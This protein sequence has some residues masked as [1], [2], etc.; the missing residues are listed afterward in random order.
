MQYLYY[1]LEAVILLNCSERH[2]YSPSCGQS[3]RPSKYFWLKMGFYFIPDARP[4]S[5]K[6]GQACRP[7]VLS[8]RGGG[9]SM[10]WGSGVT[11]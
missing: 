4:G 11:G 7:A 8:G 3:P 6:Q 9:S 2:V 1:V 5:D 10:G